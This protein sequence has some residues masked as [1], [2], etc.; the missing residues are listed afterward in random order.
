MP[1]PVYQPPPRSL[2]Q[3]IKGLLASTKAHLLHPEL[4]E[5]HIAWSFAI[6]LS[7]AFNPLMG[8]HTVMVLVCCAVSRRM[9]RPLMLVGAFV[10]NPWTLVPIATLSVYAGSLLRGQ[11]LALNLAGVRWETITWRSFVT[12]DGFQA[13]LAML[14]PVLK[15][16]LIG[17]TALC[18]LALPVGFYFMR[19]LTRR[20]RRLH[21]KL[22]HHPKEGFPHGYAI[23]DAPSPADAGKTA[24]GPTESPS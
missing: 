20:L 24:G 15:S 19:F 16:Y 13:M 6:G 18:L 4:D 17:G 2:N 21:A 11:G 14:Q 22:H 5:D 3:R 7:I 1:L 9:H 23:P 8:L 12:W 10:N